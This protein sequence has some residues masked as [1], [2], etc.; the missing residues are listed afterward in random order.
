LSDTTDHFNP[1]KTLPPPEL[2]PLLNPILGQHMGRW[3]E[4]YFTAP[5]EKREEA[6]QALLRELESEHAVDRASAEQAFAPSSET[7]QAPSLIDSGVDSALMRICDSCGHKNLPEQK[8]CGMCG[9]ALEPHPLPHADSESASAPASHQSDSGYWW[10]AQEHNVRDRSESI[11]SESEVDSGEDNLDYLFASEQPSSYSYRVIAA[12]VLVLVAAGLAF[13]AWRTVQPRLARFGRPAPPVD[14]SR[15]SPSAPAQASTSGSA[16]VPA[17]STSAPASTPAPTAAPASASSSQ[18][19]SEDE[20]KAEAKI[21]EPHPR[22]DR[23]PRNESQ[24]VVKAAETTQLT[25]AKLASGSEEFAL[26][27]DYM[28]GTNGRVRDH[29]TAA[30]WLW[31]A[32]SKKNTDATLLLADLYIKG[33]GVAKSCDQARILLDAAALKGRKDASFRLRHL[34]AFGCQ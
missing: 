20:T 28:S 3:A 11:P 4:V 25:Q 22:P 32:V 1:P 33:D 30:H 9:A 23:H 31:E 7:R 12:G 17:P 19:A 13:A 2:N 26:A 10:T 24:P 27:Q 29:A 5:P 16:T 34:Q 6:V 18:P 15:P 21:R 8:F 14:I